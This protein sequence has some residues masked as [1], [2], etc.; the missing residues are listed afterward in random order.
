MEIALS[1]DGNAGT[2]VDGV[3]RFVN[4]H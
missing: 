3:A 2:D 1:F 4:D